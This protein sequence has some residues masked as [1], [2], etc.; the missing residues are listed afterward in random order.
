MCGLLIDK[1]WQEPQG[2]E[3]SGSDGTEMGMNARVGTG[4]PRGPTSRE[5]RGRSSLTAATAWGGGG[6]SGQAGTSAE[7]GRLGAVAGS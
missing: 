1:G 2:W 6:Q 3:N 4:T 5:R 7:E